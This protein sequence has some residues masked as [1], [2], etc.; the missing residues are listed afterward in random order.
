VRLVLT[1]EGAE[2][3]SRLCGALYTTCGHGAFSSESL[4]LAAVYDGITGEEIDFSRGQTRLEPF[5]NMAVANE[6]KVLSCFEYFTLDFFSPLRLLLPAGRK[7][8]SAAKIDRLCKEDYFSR[9]DLSL[10]HIVSSVKDLGE[11][12]C[13]DETLSAVPLPWSCITQWSLVKYSQERQMHLDGLTG[14]ICFR[15]RIMSSIMAERL[16]AGQYLGIGQ[17]RRFGNGFYQITELNP[18][19]K[20]KMPKSPIFE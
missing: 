13:Q 7:L 5:N 12:P 15:G 2:Y 19:R 3:L 20:I 8:S 1:G 18:V 11:W 6:V 10:L 9:D 14:Q 17:N 4:R 16:A